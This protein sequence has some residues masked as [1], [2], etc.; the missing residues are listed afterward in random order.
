MSKVCLKVFSSPY[1]ADYVMVGMM[2]AIDPRFN[3][4][5]PPALANDIKVKVMD[6]E[7]LC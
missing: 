7:V 5:M 4:A 1:V 2:I 6:L 3:S